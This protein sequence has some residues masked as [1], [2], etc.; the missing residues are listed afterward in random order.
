MFA[1]LGD[2]EVR[3]LNQKLLSP[4]AIGAAWELRGARGLGWSWGLCNGEGVDGEVASSLQRPD[5]KTTARPRGAPTSRNVQNLPHP[6]IYPCN[7]ASEI[8]TRSRVIVKM[9]LNVK[10]I[11]YLGPDD[12]RVLTAVCAS[13]LH[14]VTLE[15]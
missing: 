2:D 6:A 11:R 10:N 13:N 12:W 7:D 4:E 9:K 1:G 8:I 3:R 5:A 14:F 15:G